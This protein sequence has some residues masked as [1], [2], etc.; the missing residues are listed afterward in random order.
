MTNKLFM[1]ALVLSIAVAYEW[2]CDTYSDPDCNP[3]LPGRRMHDKVWY[4]KWF[5][6][7]AWLRAF[8]MWDFFVYM[9]IA[10]AW[11]RL[12]R[13]NTENFNVFDFVS[14]WRWGGIAGWITSGLNIFV[15]ISL[16]ANLNDDMWGVRD[17]KE[18]ERIELGVSII[19]S[20][21][22]GQALYYFFRNGARMYAR[23]ELKAYI[24]GGDL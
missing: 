10:I 15:G 24:E 13:G 6:A 12:H 23:D 1:L 11:T 16:I 18:H 7:V 17:L 21:I 8:D 5:G 4:W 3:E 9:P 14:S 22:I 20:Q 2:D 19:I